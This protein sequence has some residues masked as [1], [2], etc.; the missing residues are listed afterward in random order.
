[1]SNK[2]TLRER[3]PD[4]YKKAAV[5]LVGLIIGAALLNK[6]LVYKEAQLLTAA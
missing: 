2:E 1:M 4:F 5:V 6:F 3:I